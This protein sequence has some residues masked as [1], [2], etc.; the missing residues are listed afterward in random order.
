MG[1]T[2][3]LVANIKIQKQATKMSEKI[4]TNFNT[5][6]EEHFWAHLFKTNDVVSYR[7]VK[8]SNILYIKTLPF[9]QQKIFAH[10]ILGA[11]EDLTNH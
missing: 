8:I 11:L 2:L 9:F 1:V 3:T 5:V 10:L 6:N 4:R 7:D